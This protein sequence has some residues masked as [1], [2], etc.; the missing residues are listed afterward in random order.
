M[1]V[2][3]I[4]HSCKWPGMSSHVG[5]EKSSRYAGK[6]R[7]SKRVWLGTSKQTAS[8]LQIII[9][10]SMNQLSRLS[11]V[12]V[13]LKPVWEKPGNFQWRLHLVYSLQWG[14]GANTTYHEEFIRLIYISY[15]FLILSNSDTNWKTSILIGIIFQR[16]IHKRILGSC[17]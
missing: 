16:Q 1:F 4:S 3:L 14:L 17:R 15:E 5:R 2:N 13:L 7:S 9:M 10:S 12:L 6:I 11:V 8:Y